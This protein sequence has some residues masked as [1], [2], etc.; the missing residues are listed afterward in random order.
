MRSLPGLLSFISSGIFIYFPSCRSGLCAEIC[1]SAL[2]HIIILTIVILHSHHHFL[3]TVHGVYSSAGDFVR[4]RE[5]LYHA[6][7]C[8]LSWHGNVN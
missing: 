5:M 4:I 8:W 3:T 2:P 1:P 6:R 7:L